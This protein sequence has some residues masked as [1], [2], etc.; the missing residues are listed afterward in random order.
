MM[1]MMSEID[2]LILKCC[3][4]LFLDG[5]SYVSPVEKS[6]TRKNKTLQ[7]TKRNI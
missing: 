3:C 1:R 7:K 6:D 2:A 4:W 5:L